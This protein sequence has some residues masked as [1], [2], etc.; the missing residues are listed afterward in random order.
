MDAGGDSGAFA[1]PAAS[2]HEIARSVYG[3]FSHRWR[4]WHADG[5][6][7]IA[8]RIGGGFHLYNQPGRMPVVTDPGIAGLAA[9]L[10]HQELMWGDTGGSS[11][12]PAR[13]LTRVHAGGGRAGEPS[14]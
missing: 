13:L 10:H 3:R 1:R 12:P 5:G 6:D 9:R 2:D 4:I 7:W 11:E 8:Y 14:S